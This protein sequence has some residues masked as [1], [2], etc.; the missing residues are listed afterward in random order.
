[1]QA[2]AAALGPHL[3]LTGG[4]G[5]PPDAEPGQGAQPTNSVERLHMGRV[6]DGWEEEP[7]VRPMLLARYRH[8]LSA[9]G[10]EACESERPLI[11]RPI[12]PGTTG[13]V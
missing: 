2:A 12:P 7:A 4:S 3:Y 8:A 6:T 11:E 10:G 13:G 9:C 5:T 1:M